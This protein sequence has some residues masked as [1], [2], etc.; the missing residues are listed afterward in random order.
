M[1]FSRFSQLRSLLIEARQEEIKEKFILS[2]FIGWQMG[3]A[4]EKTFGDYLSHLGLSDKPP[5]QKDTQDAPDD[6]AALE[7]MGIEVKKVKKE[8][9]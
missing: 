7:R 5:Q 8:D 3:A 2:A 6:T 4:G 9:T 1:S